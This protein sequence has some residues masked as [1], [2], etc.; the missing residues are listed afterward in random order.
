MRRY[1]WISICLLGLQLAAGQAFAQY[2]SPLVLVS[3]T[4]SALRQGTRLP[5]SLQVRDWQGHR[6]DSHV[7]APDSLTGSFLMVLPPR[8]HYTVSVY[9]GAC[10]VHELSLGLAADTQMY[11]LH[12]R[13]ELTPLHFFGRQVGYHCQASDYRAAMFASPEGRYDQLLALL[14][15]IVER[16]DRQGLQALSQWD[17]AFPIDEHYYTPLLQGLEHAFHAGDLQG[18]VTAG[19][20]ADASGLRCYFSEP[21]PLQ[22]DFP[23][24]DMPSWRE[25]F[26]LLQ[27]LPSYMLEIEAPASVLEQLPDQLAACG[28]SRYRFVCSTQAQLAL[29]LYAFLP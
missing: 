15:H 6:F 18:L 11:R 5:L 8:R 17:S 29:R 3:G 26:P 19:R 14:E 23:L 12:Q 24:S 2:A 9:A 27:L 13:L 4:I 21:L 1:L 22:A 25:L 7:Y 10:K 20:D 28:V 16:S